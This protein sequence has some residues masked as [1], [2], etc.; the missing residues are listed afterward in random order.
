MSD[1]AG[2]IVVIDADTHVIEPAD[3]CT[4]RI[5]VVKW[6]EMVPDGIA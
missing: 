5:S 1:G 3:F 2:S 6:A 4:S